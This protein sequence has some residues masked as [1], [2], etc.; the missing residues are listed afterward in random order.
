M[1]LGLR[2]MRCPRITVM[3]GLSATGIALCV[4]VVNSVALRPI[5]A[6]NRTGCGKGLRLICLGGK[7]HDFGA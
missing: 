6:K 7:L 2:W 3:L 5:L 1:E 4:V